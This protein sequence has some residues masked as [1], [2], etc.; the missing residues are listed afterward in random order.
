M[1]AILISAIWGVVMMFS[2]VFSKNTSVIRYVALTGLA[3]LLV[4]SYLDLSGHQLFT[5]NTRGMLVFKSFGL[6]F[7]VIA[8]GSTFLYFLLS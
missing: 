2:G 8:I 6:L 3:L 1:N 7:N 4:L 5:I